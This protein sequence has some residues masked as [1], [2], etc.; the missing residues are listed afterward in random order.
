MGLTCCTSYSVRARGIQPALAAEAQ[1]AGTDAVY[2]IILMSETLYDTSHYAT[3]ANLLATLL[4]PGSGFAYETPADLENVPPHMLTAGADRRCAPRSAC[5]L[6]ASKTYYF[7]V[8]GGTRLFEAFVAEHGFASV[9]SVQ[10]VWTTTE[11]VHREI[12]RI[13]R[14]ST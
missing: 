14:L 9:L 4:R 7:G 2:D 12:L 11:T 5:R 6:V 10:P 8:G 13:H 1:A 3:L